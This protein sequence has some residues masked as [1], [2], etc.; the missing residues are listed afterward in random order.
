MGLTYEVCTRKGSVHPASGCL[1]CQPP[2]SE[3]L[4]S[5]S[6]MTMLGLF[7]PSSRV[8]FLRLL[9]PAAIWIWWPTC[10]EAET[11]TSSQWGEKEP[12]ALT[13]T[14]KDPR[15]EGLAGSQEA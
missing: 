9:L 5:A 12:S 13:G 8:T 14:E 11:Q 6:D 4:L 10:R 3:N 2:V 15:L 7:P 1:Q